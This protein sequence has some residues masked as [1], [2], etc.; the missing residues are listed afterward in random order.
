MALR[1]VLPLLSSSSGGGLEGKLLIGG[2]KEEE[3]LGPPFLLSMQNW[4]VSM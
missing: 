2:H 3:G 1:G 4:L